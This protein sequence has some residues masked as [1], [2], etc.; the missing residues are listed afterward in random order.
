MK[1]KMMILTMLALAMMSCSEE[2]GDDTPMP[3]P[4]QDEQTEEKKQGHTAT[5]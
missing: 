4:Q 5:L 3:Q 1:T 2:A